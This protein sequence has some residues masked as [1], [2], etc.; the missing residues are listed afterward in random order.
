MEGLRKGEDRRELTSDRGCQIDQS[1][2][3]TSTS[4]KLQTRQVGEQE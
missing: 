2:T 1:Q 3:V 4:S